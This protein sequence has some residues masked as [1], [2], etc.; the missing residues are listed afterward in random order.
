[1]SEL[2]GIVARR[3]GVTVR[4]LHHYEA[5]GLLIPGTRDAAGYRRYS[6]ADEERLR[7]ILY[8]RGLG[9]ALQ[10]IGALLDHP[11]REG[12]TRQHDAARRRVEEAQGALDQWDEVANLRKVGIRLAPHDLPQAFGGEKPGRW[13]AEAR[14]RFGQTDAWDEAKRRTSRY[15]REDW[16]TIRQE[17]HSLGDKL[18][19]LQRSRVPA[20]DPRARELAE[21]HRRHIDRWFYPCSRPMHQGLASLYVSDP[22][23]QAYFDRHGPGLAAYL[24]GAIAATATQTSGG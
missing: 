1:M 10:D 15:S 3:H 9:V 21:A 4:L 17:Q 20:N 8:Y 6:A 14:E 22:R 11:D 13:T 7:A 23:F 24:A 12:W 5:I 18:A 19:A 16:A 2:V